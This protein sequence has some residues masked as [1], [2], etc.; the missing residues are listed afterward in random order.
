MEKHTDPFEKTDHFNDWGRKTFETCT[1]YIEYSYHKSAPAKQSST[2]TRLKRYGPDRKSM[3]IK[4]TVG[5]K[6]TTTALWSSGLNPAA[7]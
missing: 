6:K 1:R 5:S 2:T 4:S 7:A 3:F